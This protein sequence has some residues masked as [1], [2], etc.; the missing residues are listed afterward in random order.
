LARAAARGRRARAPRMRFAADRM[1]GRLARWLRVIGQ[2]VVYGSHLAGAALVR[3][4]RAAGRVILTR[5]TRLLRRR[6]LPPHLFIESDRFRE[7]LRQVVAAF[8]LDPAAG[9]LTRCLDCNETL[10]A[11]DRARVRG[12]VPPYVW[13]TQDR[14]AACPRCRRVFWAATHLERMRRELVGLGLLGPADDEPPGAPSG[15]P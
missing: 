8:G 9:L 14:F 11:A 7:Q 4:A 15:T 12:R 1:L 3:E 10:V 13:A 2:D 5:D 6:D